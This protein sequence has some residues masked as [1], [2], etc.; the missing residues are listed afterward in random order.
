MSLY[1]LLGVQFFGELKNH[2]VLNSTTKQDLTI[3]SLAIPDTFCSMDTESGYQCPVGMKCMKMDFIDSYIQGFNGFEDIAT[4]IFTVYQAASQEGWVFIMY[5]AIDS[6]PAWRAAFYFSTMIFFLAWLVKNVFIAV[7]TE[8]F[9]EIRVQFQQMWGVRGKIQN[10]ITSHTLVGD[11][12]GWK[13][14]TIDDNKH[15]SANETCHR[16]IKSPYFRIFVMSVILANGIVTASMNFKHDGRKREVFYEKHYYIEIVFTIFFDLETIFKVFCLGFR[17]YFKHSIHK[18]ELLLAIGTT[19][20]IVPYFYLSGFTYFQVLR[21]VRLIKASPILEGFVYKIFGPGKKLGSL[22]IFTMCLLIISSS[23]SMQLFCFLCDF[24]KF[25]TFPEA[26][27]SMFQIL[28]QEAWVEVMDETMNRT[29]KFFT[30]LVAIY[31]ILYHLFVTLIVLSLFV[32][33]I[34]DNLELDEDIKKLKQLKFREQS[35]EIKETL[36]FRLRIFEKF[37]DSPQM[38]ILHKIPS[39]F[40]LPKVRE[41]FMKQFVIDMDVDDPSFSEGYKRPISECWESNV[42]F[43]KQR[44][45]KMINKTRKVRTIGSSLRKSAITHIINDSN[46]QRLMLGDSAMIPVAG[47]KPGIKTQGTIQKSGWRVDQKK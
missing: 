36:P 44:P 47:V 43:K 45:V 19:I 15:G 8:T 46:N 35:A 7:I 26:F 32:A 39:D 18:F 2:C 29:P 28:T 30:P 4:S 27:M 1:G 31:F 6:L 5:R 33:V 23:I 13:L 21:V 34:L 38:T 22:I 9:N 41:S 16:L 14:V 25:E 42:M 40:S 12:T 20:H 11:D 3:N 10:N 37:P 17:G 24:T